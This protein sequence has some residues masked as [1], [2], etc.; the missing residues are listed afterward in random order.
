MKYLLDGLLLFLVCLQ[1]F[2]KLLVR[3]WLG[4]KAV[5]DLIYIVDGVIELDWSPT[6]FSRM[7]QWL[8]HGGYGLVLGH[9]A[10]VRNSAMGDGAG[11]ILSR[12]GADGR[13]VPWL[14]VWRGWMLRLGGNRALHVIWCDHLNRVQGICGCFNFV[15]RWE[16]G[17]ESHNQVGV[18]PE[19]MRHALNDTRGIDTN[20]KRK[21]MM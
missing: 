9:D 3:F 19:Q 6:R 12:V 17:V 1:N 2:E 14:V 21:R 7:L 4:C 20:D 13:G 15:A 11:R 16:E 10:G 5:L 18:T 8:R